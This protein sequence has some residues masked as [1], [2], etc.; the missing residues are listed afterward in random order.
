M[1]PQ[2]HRNKYKEYFLSNE[3]FWINTL[4]TLKKYIDDNKK[5]PSESSKNKKIIAPSNWFGPNMSSTILND[6]Y[7][8][9]MIII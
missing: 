3:E 7:T 6:L 1:M 5:R 2:H 4:E 8:K 9:N